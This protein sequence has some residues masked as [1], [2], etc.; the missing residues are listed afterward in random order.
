MAEESFFVWLI[1]SVDDIMVDSV[2]WVVFLA[3]VLLCGPL[4][5]LFVDWNRIRTKRALYLQWIKKVVTERDCK[6]HSV[7]ETASTST[8][9]SNKTGSDE[10][11]WWSAEKISAENLAGRL[12]P[13]DA[14]V[15]ASHR[16]HFVG[17]VVLNAVA[18]EFYDQAVATAETLM[19]Q[20]KAD[21]STTQSMLLYGVPIS[22]KECLNLQG[23][24]STGGLACRLLHGRDKVDSLVVQVIREG[25][26]IPVVT[27]NVPQ[28]LMLPESVNRIWGRS[29]NPYDVTRT[30]GGS[31]GG[32]AALVSSGCVP[33]A[34]A[35]DVAG[36]IRIPASFCG[37]CGFKPSTGRL[38]SL[39]HMEPS[40]DDRSGTAIAIPTELGPMARTV[41]DCAQ[42]MRAVSVPS[43]WQGDLSLVPLPWRE[44]LYSSSSNGNT[45]KAELRIGYF[46]TD[47]WFEPCA[48]SKRAVHET[49][50]KL[51]Q[52]GHSVQ[53]FTLPTDG[54]FSYGLLAAIDV[55]E[56]NCRSYVEALEGEEHIAE[57]NLLLRAATM[58]NWIRWL[59]LRSGF[60][61]DRIAHL[62]RQTVSGGISAYELWQKMAD[63][64][65]MRRKWSSAM[66]DLDALIFPAMPIPAM[67]H[68][69]SG[70]LTSAC[71]YMFLANMLL[72]PSGVVPVTTVRPDEAHYKCDDGS[73]PDAIRNDDIAKKVASTVC[74]ADSV[75]LPIGISVMTTSYQDELCLRVMKEVE[76]L[77][78]FT[79]KPPSF[80]K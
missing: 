55:A 73:V 9:T 53:P 74:T 64:Q 76:R 39:G 61:D 66:R 28:I 42:F 1:R 48:T 45:K 13:R 16:C 65:E 10:I 50:E 3:C 49:V 72:W 2:P 18:E 21:I 71:S 63:L 14:V 23:S 17:K 12:T 24:Y 33:L 75:G 41:E 5:L 15:Q 67:K 58:P 25:G 32:D 60:L 59:I 34:V 57:Y 56:G 54:W 6:V 20:Q 8:G 27:G 26:A 35:S 69:T 78:N 44:D 46:D 36:S 29:V 7:L 47:G 40:L 11:Q 68:G 43:M 30:P 37:I 62:F 38:S 80:E 52:A 31:S 22:V 19:K 77:V 51:R 70:E 79:A 4:F